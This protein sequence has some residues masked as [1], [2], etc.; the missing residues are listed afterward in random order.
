MAN[1]GVMKLKIQLYITGINDILIYIHME[2]S[3]F[4]NTLFYAV[5]ATRYMY[6]LSCSNIK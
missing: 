4:G 1:T 3:Y 2:S 5:L 6:L